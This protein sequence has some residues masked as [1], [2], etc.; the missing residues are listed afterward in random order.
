ML[1]LGNEK[2]DILFKITKSY[3]LARK[4]ISSLC[5]TAF[6]AVFATRSF[7]VFFIFFSF[8]EVFAEFFREAVT[9]FARLHEETLNLI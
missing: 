2:L 4:N 9:V 3:S 1:T 7:S 5:L 8:E 6:E